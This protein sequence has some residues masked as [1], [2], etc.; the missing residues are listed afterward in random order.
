MTA[1]S[2][3]ASW[4]PQNRQLRRPTAT[5]R[6][7][8]SQALSKSYDNACERGIKPVAQGRSA[9]L[10]CKNDDTA[11]STAILYSFMGCCRAAGVDFRKWMIYFLELVHQYDDD[12]SKDLDELL[13]DNL[14]KAGVL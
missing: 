5:G 10:F 1:A 14:K 2:S 3:A 9:Y 6:T 13:P 4:L 12:Y 11:E 7:L 8:F